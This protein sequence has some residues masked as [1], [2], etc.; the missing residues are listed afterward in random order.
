MKILILFAHPKISES[1]VQRRML[2]AITE[3]ERV[4]VHDLYAA[5]PDFDIDVEREQSL[6]LDHDVI[7]FQH[8]FYWY[9]SPSIVKEW[10]DLVLDHGWAY[11]PGGTRLH[12]KF[13]LQALSTG[14]PETAYH[15]KGR[16]RFKV[17]D[18][19]SPFNQTAYLCGMGWLEPFIIYVGRHLEAAQLTQEVEAYRDLIIGLR[20][21]A[22]P[23]LKRIAKATTLP[24]NFRQDA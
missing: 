10:Q 9:S 3:L 16:N 19:L 13:M 18:L 4:T 17:T 6:L 20:D 23:P 12:G 21:G 22:I 5:Y 24:A 15:H 7:V 2:A 14:G 11:G 1:I 8:P